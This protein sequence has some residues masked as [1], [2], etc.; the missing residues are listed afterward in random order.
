MALVVLLMFSVIGFV[1]AVV[2]FLGF[3]FSTIAAFVVYFGLALFGPAFLLPLTRI[4]GRMAGEG[5][6]GIASV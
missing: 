3:G 2:G 4:I 5:A 1:T 6:E